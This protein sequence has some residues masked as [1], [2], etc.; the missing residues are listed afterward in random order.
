M[1]SK[2]INHIYKYNDDIDVAVDVI[3]FLINYIFSNK[4]TPH[5]HYTQIKLMLRAYSVS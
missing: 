1:I 5:A 2:I 4:I 3:S